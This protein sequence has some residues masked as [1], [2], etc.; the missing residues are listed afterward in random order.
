M[1]IHDRIKDATVV[2]L[3]PAFADKLEKVKGD[4]RRLGPATIRGVVEWDGWNQL[5]LV[6]AIEGTHRTYA[7][8][9]LGIPLI[10]QR[11]LPHDV[12]GEHDVPGLPPETT[13]GSI[14]E[15]A[16]CDQ[17]GTRV[18]VLKP[19]EDRDKVAAAVAHWVEEQSGLDPSGSSVE[20]STLG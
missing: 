14:A 9:I 18:V 13:A 5:H 17:P 1:D 8:R 7:S 16:A 15:Y 2:T 12:I 20:G 3:H 19:G 10:V 4:M 11:V 6:Y